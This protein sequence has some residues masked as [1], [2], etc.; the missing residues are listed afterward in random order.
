MVPIH[1]NSSV[2]LVKSD[3][4]VIG[5]KQQDVAVTLMDMLVC[6]VSWVHWILL[7][8]LTK[9]RDRVGCTDFYVNIG[10]G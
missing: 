1:L 3:E 6:S 9:L 10:G 5:K 4:L 8:G 7:K 2:S